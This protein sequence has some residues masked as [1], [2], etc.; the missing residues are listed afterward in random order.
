MSDEE[1]PQSTQEARELPAAFVANQWKPGQ[2]G[3][4]GGKAKKKPLTEALERA[5]ANDATA[6]ELAEA[7]LSVIKGKGKGTAQA[8]KEARECVEGKIADRHEHSGPDG[9]PVQGLIRVE[10]VKA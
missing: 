4:P 9:S 5:L 1:Q 6:D 10:F 3:N 7:L 2:S 8:F